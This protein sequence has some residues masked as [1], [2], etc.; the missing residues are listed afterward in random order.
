MMDSGADQIVE[1]LRSALVDNERLKLQNQRLADASTE[2]IAIVGMSCRL[3]GGADSPEALW[4]LV[5]DG[6]DAVS[7]VPTDRGWDPAWLRGPDE[8]ADAPVSLEGGFVHDAPCFD[9]APFGISPREALAMDPQQRL[10]LEATWEALERGG[11]DPTALKGTPTGVFVGCSASGYSATMYGDAQGSESYLLTGTAGGVLSGRISYAFGLEGPAVT[12][13]TACSSSSVALHLAVQS[14]RKGECTLA[15]AGG[16]AVIATPGVFSEFSKQGGLAADGRCKAFADSADGTGWAE[17]T[18]MVLLE[19]LSEARRNGHEVLA[20][21]RGSAVNQ[22]GA[23]N[24]LTAPSGPAQRR[25]IRQALADARLTTADVD[26]VEAH[27]TGTTLGDPIEAQALLATYGQNRPEDRPLWLGSLKSNMGHPQATA[28]VAGVIKMVMAIRNGV[29]P[30]TLHAEEPST[31]V[32]WSAGAVRLL[33]EQRPWPE[34]GRARRAGVS[35]FGMSGTN[36]HL[37]VEEATEEE[38]PATPEREPGKAASVAGPAVVPWVLSAKTEKALRAQAGRLLDRVREDTDTSLT[39]IGYS[40]AL[41]RTAFN[42][43]A[44]VVAGERADFLTAL[45]SLAEGAPAATAMSGVAGRGSRPVFVFPG[46][47]AQW[48]GMAVE[49]LESSPVF[50]A[51]M[52][53]CAAALEP[54]V[55]WSLLD[56]V[57][58]IDGAPGLDR[59]DVVQPVLWAVMVS[60]AEVWRSYGVEPA[61][62]IGHSQGEIAAAAVAGILTLNDA[63]KVVALRSRAITALAGRG[64]M[65]SVAQPAA[66][67]REKITA[68]GGRISI[69]AVNG[70]SSVVVSG[71]PEALDELVVD[72]RSNDI[73]ARRIDVDYASHSAHVEEIEAELARLL[74]GTEPGAGDVA[75]YSSLT[76]AVLSGTEMGSG[77]W[78]DNLRETVEFEQATRAALADGHSIFIEV[79]PHPVLAIGL[80]GTVENV[81]ADAAV[82]GTLRR[83]EGGQDRFLTSLAEAHVHGTTIDW[84]TVFA[85]T[86]ATR[87]HLPTY[88]FQRTHYWPAPPAPGTFFPAPAPSGESA[89]TIDEEEV[90]QASE[91]FAARLRD[92]PAAERHWLLVGL[93]AQHAAAVLGHDSAEAIEKDTNFLEQGFD[94]LTALRMRNNLQQVLGI[95]LSPTLLFD[96]STPVRLARH[97]AERLLGAEAGTEDDETADET[98]QPGANG[99]LGQLFRHSRDIGKPVEYTELLIN[100]ASFRPTYED[101]TSLETPHRAVPL[102]R[103]GGEKARPALISCCTMSMLSGAHEYARLAAGFRG[104]RDV[105]A[106]P[107]PGFGAGQD[108]PASR[109]ILLRTHADTVLRTVGDRP[110][111]LTGHSGGAMVANV[112]SLE[113]ARQGRAPDAVVLMDSYPVDSEVLVNW[114]PQMLDGMVERDSAYTP[115]DDYRTTAWAAYLQFFFDWKARPLDVPTLLVRAADP[116]GTIPEDADWRAQ[117]PYEHDVVDV[118]GDHFTML[119]DH[120]EDVAKRIQEWLNDQGL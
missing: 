10:L 73:R 27:G 94:S 85:G 77:Y 119:G 118:P 1:A 37:I 42:H 113:L 29:L 90:A 51:R 15:V 8:P 60:L 102:G 93:V 86:G 100:L 116:L 43:R 105:Y 91:E 84:T 36:V 89:G 19:R 62:V 6:R 74:A 55:E 103:S 120:S 108:L 12:V 114:I 67:M 58:G 9:P 2:P 50:A 21:I 33:D 41:T 66:W 101:H 4:Q 53:Q 56:V 109:D 39:D 107:H 3:P 30:R 96:H 13:D 31:H 71:D 63:A 97:L 34:T 47:G 82:L 83:Q 32:K 59:V 78:Y 111:V 49:L 35:S 20:V 69:A 14:L 70:P 112:L 16:A 28:G 104:V 24:G 117:W 7:A 72:C 68:W 88:A 48:T 44:A 54:Y 79:S 23:S 61:A 64:G 76:G 45:E 99:L 110:F 65:V 38:Q 98:P 22:D 80:Q 46:Q 40:L 11:F 81:G 115:M 52:A 57:R 106:L 18:G 17:G 95:T 26:V 5:L 87:T 92:T 25:V 75:L